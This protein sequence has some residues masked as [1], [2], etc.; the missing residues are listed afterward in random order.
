MSMYVCVLDDCMSFLVTFMCKLIYVWVYVCCVGCHSYFMLSDHRIAHH[1]N[2]NARAYC[3]P[4]PGGSVFLSC[5]QGR[6]S[7]TDTQIKIIN[8]NI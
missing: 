3:I 5:I 6:K 8:Q 4:L 2:H 7:N 1:T